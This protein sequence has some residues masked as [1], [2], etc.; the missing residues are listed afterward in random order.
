MCDSYAQLAQAANAYIDIQ[1]D[2]KGLISIVPFSNT[3]SILYER[4]TKRIT[5][6]EGYTGG[7]TNFAAALQK[8]LEIVG[9]NDARYECRI[10]F[11]TDGEATVP[12]AEL[13]L[14]TGKG[15]RMD[16]VGCGTEARQ[17]T[18]QQLVTCGGHLYQGKIEEVEKI[19]E[20]IAATEENAPNR[21]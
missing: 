1:E 16:V 6:T 21:S 5:N 15:I 10:V 14:L 20:I 11:F 19:F 13:K 9:R 4:G 2:R 3:A 12:T 8:A 17:A 18:L 7:G